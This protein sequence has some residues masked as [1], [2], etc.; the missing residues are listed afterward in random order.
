[1]RSRTRPN[2]DARRIAR[3]CV[4]NICGSASEKRI[5]R[6]DDLGYVRARPDLKAPPKGP[7]LFT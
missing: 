4:R 6:S 7:N 5:A 2:C 1:M 3:N